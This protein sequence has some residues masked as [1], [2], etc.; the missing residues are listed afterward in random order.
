MLIIG[1]KEKFAI[2]YEEIRA[3]EIQKP[4]DES[5][6]NMWVN[7]S[8]LCSFSFN[9]WILSCFYG[10][11]SLI[12]NWFEKNLNIIL[13]EKKFPLDIEAEFS[14]DFINKYYSFN[15][16][17][18]ICIYEKE[19]EKVQAW[20]WSHNW[21]NCRDGS[22]IPNVYFRRVENKIEIEWN[23]TKSFEGEIFDNQKGRE[24]VDVHLF[25]EVIKTFINA[26]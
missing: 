7:G 14:I 16:S 5:K 9:N 3:K 18:N 21:Y 20:L 26:S 8:Q 25:T 13:M 19:F 1:L 10:N 15:N 12:R 11:I 17:D 22:F 6:F 4:S 23:N 24:Y 2:E